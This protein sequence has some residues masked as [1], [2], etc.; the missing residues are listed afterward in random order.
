LT[1][2]F[3]GAGDVVRE[4]HRDRLHELAMLLEGIELDRG[5]RSARSPVRW[6]GSGFRSGGHSDGFVLARASAPLRETLGEPFRDVIRLHLAALADRI[7]REKFEEIAAQVTRATQ[8]M[9]DFPAAVKRALDA[10][11][12]R[13]I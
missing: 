5:T 10:P 12:R 1:F 11:R 3:S 7:G 2:P 9:K 8:A 13:A 4:K 6:T